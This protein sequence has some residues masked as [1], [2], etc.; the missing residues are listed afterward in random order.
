MAQENVRDICTRGSNGLSVDLSILDDQIVG[1]LHFDHRSENSR[2]AF[3]VVDSNL[4]KGADTAIVIPGSPGGAGIPIQSASAVYFANCTLLD[5]PPK[6]PKRRRQ[7]HKGRAH[8]VQPTIL[9]DA[10]ELFGLAARC[11]GR[12]FDYDM[13]AVLQGMAHQPAVAVRW[14]DD[15]HN[16]HIGLNYFI[17]T[18]NQLQTR[19]PRFE[20][21]P[22]FF[23]PS[24]YRPKTSQTARNQ[25]V[26]HL[27]IR[28]DH[29]SCTDDANRYRA[30]GSCSSGA[31][32]G[33]VS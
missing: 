10:I 7:L 14:R 20:F 33:A 4:G 11:R 12:L 30:Q 19:A 6:C 17:W 3:Q 23:A 27:E 18:G 32:T 21:W 29:I 22:A 16:I 2:K 31:G 25:A 15:K 5:S 1:T 26:Q 24:A 28:P 9:G 8:Q 13:L